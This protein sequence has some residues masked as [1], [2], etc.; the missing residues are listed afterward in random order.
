MALW[1]NGPREVRPSRGLG[2]DAGAT[3]MRPVFAITLTRGDQTRSFEIRRSVASG[4][5]IIERENASLTRQRHCA[6]WHRVELG[7][8]SFRQA[9]AELRK[10]GWSLSGPAL[11]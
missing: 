10:A 9:V 6:D 2:K 7:I 3:T 8:T 4:W 1:Q 11:G 5:D